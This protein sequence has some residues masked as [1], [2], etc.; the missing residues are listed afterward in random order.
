MHYNT[1]DIILGNSQ[2]LCKQQMTLINCTVAFIIICTATL[3]MYRYHTWGLLHTFPEQKNKQGKYPRDG[4][5]QYK[6]KRCA[7]PLHNVLWTFFLG[8]GGAHF[9]FDFMGI[10]EDTIPDICSRLF[11]VYKYLRKD[12]I[13]FCTV[14]EIC[15]SICTINF[16]ICLWIT[17]L[18]DCKDISQTM[19]FRSRIAFYI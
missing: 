5:V 14:M 2:K 12:F 13:Q 7:G 19:L 10:S 1:T 6:K 8:G 3:C 18:I 4:F 9:Y 16:Y 15:L 17:L 11:F